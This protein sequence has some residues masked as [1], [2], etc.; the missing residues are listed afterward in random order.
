VPLDEGED[1]RLARDYA[2]PRVADRSALPA[3]AGS[4]DKR[5]SLRPPR[6][7]RFSL[8]RSRRCTRIRQAPQTRRPLPVTPYPLPASAPSPAGHS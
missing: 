6:P 8:F 7:Q 5:G 1:A 3:V 4:S 2:V